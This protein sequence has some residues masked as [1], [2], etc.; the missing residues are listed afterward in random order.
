M[1]FGIITLLATFAIMGWTIGLAKKKGAHFQVLANGDKMLK[2]HII[3]AILGYFLGILLLFFI[4]IG[5]YFGW[6]TKDNETWSSYIFPIVVLLAILYGFIHLTFYYYNNRV[7]Y[8]AEIITSYN[9][10]GKTSCIKW[11]DLTD[12]EFNKN[13][14]QI[15]LYSKQGERIKMSCFLYGLNDFER[16]FASHHPYMIQRILNRSLF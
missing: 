6:E 8:N 2:N 11:E 5:F 15:R 16:E 12:A 14:Q 7:I 3:F 4:G 13:M 1:S 9:A 10:W